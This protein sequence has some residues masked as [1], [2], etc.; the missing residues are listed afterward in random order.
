MN[1]LHPPLKSTLD[2]ET[3]NQLPFLDV[4]VRRQ[5]GKFKRSVYRKPTFTGLY[6][7]WESFGPT[8]QKIALIRSL[9]SRAIKICSDI[10]FPDEI[11]KLKEL[12]ANNGYPA[13]IVERTISDTIAKH[14]SKAAD[15]ANSKEETTRVF[16][17]LPWLGNVSNQYRKQIS[18]TMMGCYP[19]V[20]PQV[21][22][23]T[24][25]AFN[26]RTKDVLPTTAKSYVVY[27]F[28]CSCGLT[29]V[30]RTSQCLL[31]RIKQ[32]I[33]VSMLKSE[34]RPGSVKRTDSAITRHLKSSRQCIRGDLHGAFKVLAQARNKPHLDVLEVL[35]IQRLA[36]PLCNQK[37]H[38]RALSLF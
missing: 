37:E 9:T 27:L 36:P 19:Q 21:V 3:D 34:A 25:P 38:V 7:R 17:R 26:G 6:T 14:E 20:K 33:P 32:H 15:S 22:F 18:E 30:G 4:R 23:T 11:A 12:F 29:Y 2:A 16:L 8:S 13:Q 10:A 28:T 5:D 35:N 24:R 31:E 1:D